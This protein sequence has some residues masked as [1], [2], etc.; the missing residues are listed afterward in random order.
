MTVD[1][2]LPGLLMALF[3]VVKTHLSCCLSI[4]STLPNTYCEVDP[5]DGPCVYRKLDS[6]ILVVKTTEHRL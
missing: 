5:N 3:S 4:P 2:G 6:G 1:H